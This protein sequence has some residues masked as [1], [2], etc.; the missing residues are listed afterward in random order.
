MARKPS[1]SKG[2]NNRKQIVLS[3]KGHNGCLARQR[4]KQINT[5]SGWAEKH[6]EM[7]RDQEKVG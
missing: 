5:V 2:E 4:R 6:L 3:C 1:F 7:L